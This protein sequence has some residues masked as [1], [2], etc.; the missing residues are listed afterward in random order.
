MDS[1]TKQTTLN[2]MIHVFKKD[3]QQHTFLN[4]YPLICG[5]A[6]KLRKQKHN[7]AANSLGFFFFGTEGVQ[8]YCVNIHENTCFI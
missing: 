6:E 5:Q 8:S 1:Q 4:F 2:T 3:G 7:W